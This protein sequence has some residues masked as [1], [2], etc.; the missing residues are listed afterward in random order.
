MIESIMTCAEKFALICDL[1]HR[2]AEAFENKN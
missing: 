1:Q 2:K